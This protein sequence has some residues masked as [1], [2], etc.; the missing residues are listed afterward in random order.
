MSGLNWIHTCHSHIKRSVTKEF[1]DIDVSEKQQMSEL[2]K[3]ELEKSEGLIS[4]NTSLVFCFLWKFYFLPEFYASNLKWF[5]KMRSF[6]RAI[7]SI[8]LQSLDCKYDTVVKTK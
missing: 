4:E 7:M 8:C 3:S 6:I 2:E 5:Y 1:I